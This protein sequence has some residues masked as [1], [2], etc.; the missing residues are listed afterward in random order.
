MRTGGRTGVIA[1]R[2]AG[3]VTGGLPFVLLA[4]GGALLA[5]AANAGTRASR[6]KNLRC[7]KRGTTLGIAAALPLRPGL[8]TL[9]NLAL[10]Q[11]DG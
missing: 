8:S 3:R 7:I 9:R 4:R 11:D 1:G 6:T 5:Q 2:P 10:R